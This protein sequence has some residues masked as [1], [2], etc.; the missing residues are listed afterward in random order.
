MK[1]KTAFVSDFDGTI[2]DDDFFTY[3]SKA[4]FDEK[5]LAPWLRYKKGE[6]SHFEALKEMFAKIRVPLDELNSFMNTIPV[7]AGFIAAAQICHAKNIPVYICSAGCNYYIDYLIGNIIKEYN[8][9]LVTNQ[10]SYNPQT[11]LIM[12]MPLAE[13][14]YFSPETGISKAA[15]VEHLH[16]EGY[17]VIY[18]GDG[19]PDYDAARNADKVFARRDLLV[20]CREAG[21]EASAFADFGLINAYLKE[22]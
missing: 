5:S 7:D 22:L 11:G 12:Q 10:S 9:T 13:N 20:K 4:F 2:T 3:A 6:I 21:I 1:E 16:R 17:K 14:P 18:A 19:L 8:I 15:I